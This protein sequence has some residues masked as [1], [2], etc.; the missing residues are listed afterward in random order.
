MNGALGFTFLIT[1]YTGSTS[2]LNSI[3]RKHPLS[4]SH[5]AKRSRIDPI[6][7]SLSF[8]QVSEL[9][10]FS[11]PTQIKQ[12]SM[13]LSP[14]KKRPLVSIIIPTYNCS[15]YLP[16][17]VRSVIAQTYTNWEL[18]IV[19]DGSSDDTRKVC[20]EFLSN[21]HITYHFRNN[22]GVSAARNYGY[23]IAKGDLIAYL[24]SDDLWEPGN[25]KDKIEYLERH[26]QVGLVHGDMQVID[27][28]SKPTGDVLSGREGAI[29]ED[30]LL[31]NGTNIPGPSSI[32]VRREAIDAI[33][34]FDPELST[35]ADQDFF[36]RCASMF[37]VGRVNKVSGSY[38]VHEDNMH[39]NIALMERDHIYVYQKARS[40]GLFH[41]WAFRQ[42]CFS[43]LYLIL[44]GSWWVNGNDKQRGL[45]FLFK[46]IA[47]YPPNTLQ[48]FKKLLK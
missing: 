34:G 32:L 15:R 48:V 19:D 23:S 24:D 36:F 13:I 14:I 11:A 12:K 21:Q 44:A 43:N 33:G 47:A 42:K 17:T 27:S 45:Y 18:I 20:D 30:L 22:A 1:I 3:L 25:L 26:Q 40:S 41:S 16:E 2:A 46:S 5:H 29:L 28:S 39:K 4:T 31:W 10:T 8:T 37:L 9:K 6:C 7:L 38:R 35:A